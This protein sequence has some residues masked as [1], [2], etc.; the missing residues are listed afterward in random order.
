MVSKAT[1]AG[2]GVA[3]TFG[4][5][6]KVV[7]AV[8]GLNHTTNKVALKVTIATNIVTVTPASTVGTDADGVYDVIADCI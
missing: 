1:N 7:G 2:S 5:Y 3:V 6:E 8:A 4:E